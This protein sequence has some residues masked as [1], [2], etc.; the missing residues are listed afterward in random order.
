MVPAIF[1]IVP[2]A[3][4]VPLFLYETWCA[5]ARLHNHEAG[6]T[7]Y[8]DATWEVTHTFLILAVINTIWLYSS[9]MTTIAKSVYWGL[10]IAG[11]LFIVRGILYM[12]L[13]YMQDF[14]KHNRITILDWLFALSHIGILGG[15]VYTIVQ[16]GR[17]LLTQSYS[18]NTQFIPFMWPGLILLLALGAIP[19]LKLYRTK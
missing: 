18:V 1:V 11:A 2:L 6:K 8:V 5:F 12:Y 10:L 3:L 17:I 13:F 19:L 14:K 7:G 16:A 4:Y 15:L 9:I